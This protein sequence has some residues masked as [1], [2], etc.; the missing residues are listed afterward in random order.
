MRSELGF[1]E[2][3]RLSYY[4]D[5]FIKAAELSFTPQII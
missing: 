4:K 2:S 1:H 3:Q 5:K